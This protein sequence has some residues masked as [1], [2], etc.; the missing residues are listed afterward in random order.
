MSDDLARV[1]I[2]PPIRDHLDH[3]QGPI[4]LYQHARGADPAAAFGTCTD[5]VARAALVDLAQATG[6]GD[7][8]ARACRASIERHLRYLADAFDRPSGR[9]RNLF[10]D[11]GRWDLRGESDDAH[12]RAIQALAI[13]ASRAPWQSVRTKA[14]TLLEPALA[15]ATSLG[16]W[17]SAAYL[18][19]GCSVAL[20][21][22]GRLGRMV[23]PVLER[24]LRDLSDPFI[25][26]GPG[27]PW[28]EPS[29]TYDNGSIPNALM[30]GGEAT[31]DRQLVETGRV[32]LTFLAEG[33]TSAAGHASLVGN[34]GWWPRNGSKATFDQQPIDADAMVQ[35]FA[36]A[37]RL[38]A[39]PSDRD[40]AFRFYRWFL[41][42]NDGGA[43]VARPRN[44]ACHD[45]LTPT[46]VNANQGAESTLAWL[47]SLE[48]VR[49]I[50][51]LDDTDPTRTVVRDPAL[52]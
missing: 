20:A 40:Q 39:D 30:T 17:R 2:W 5:D 48:A 34:D 22:G 23:K 32:T 21:Q 36:T 46:G 8:D 51:T 44:G 6:V 26:V 7:V 47:S 14:E 10:D 18:T 31:G 42:E 41:G 19:L 43:R 3:L 37:Y 33:Q 35:A 12:A 28:P 24:A 1:L 52:A 11:D 49:A 15:Q 38:S 13:I 50:I 29:V 9:F 4:G 16:Y 27:W 25:G 45:G